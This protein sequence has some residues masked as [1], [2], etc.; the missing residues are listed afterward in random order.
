MTS[1]WRPLETVANRSAPMACGPNVD[2]ARPPAGAVALRVADLA[3]KETPVG[4]PRQ[5][6]PAWAIALLGGALAGS[7]PGTSPCIDGLSLVSGMV[8]PQPLVGS[9]HAHGD[10]RLE[11]EAGKTSARLDR[12]TPC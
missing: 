4:C 6:S 8:I 9:N 11:Q 5:A 10:G 7:G 1:R 3:G 12:P 2:Q